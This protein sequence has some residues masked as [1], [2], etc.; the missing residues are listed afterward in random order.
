MIRRKKIL[1]IED[2]EKLIKIIFKV[3]INALRLTPTR[4]I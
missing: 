1:S 3:R 4:K 2:K